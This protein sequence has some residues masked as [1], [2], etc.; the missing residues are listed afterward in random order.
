MTITSI[1]LASYQRIIVCFSGGK[2]SL[3]CLLWL[4]EQGV[5]TDLI[6]LHHHL[7]DGNEGSD[8][9]DWPVTEAYC[10][11]I[12]KA[13]GLRFTTSW[14]V[15]GLEGEMDRNNESTAPIAIPCG[16]GHR[17]IGGD[18][19]L[20]T[21]RMF[22]QVTHNLRQRWC[23]SYA[24]IDCFSR[25]VCNDDSFNNSRTLVITGER[26]EESPNRAHYAVF[27]PHSTDRRSS[28]KLQRHVDHLRPVHTWEERRVWE[29]IERWSVL[30]HPAYF[31]GVG[32]VSC[33]FCIFSSPNQWA[34]N[35]KIS[36][37]RFYRIANK[38][39]LFNVTIQ[40]TRSVVEMANAGVPLNAEQRWVDMALSKTFDHPVITRCWVLPSGAY[41]ESCGPT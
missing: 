13:F 35:R 4:F 5:P 18:G 2:D 3:A 37:V 9:M 36:P 17:K 39:A 40:R 10:K 27:E 22:P 34:T 28:A 25:W 8:L 11:A 33:Q 41:G 20:G 1:S 14:K 38:E 6:E 26:A 16:D 23:S 31:I 19:P 29:I 12:A 15:N 24:K 30:P 21:R 32:R 7:V